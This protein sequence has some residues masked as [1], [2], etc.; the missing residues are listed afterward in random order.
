MLTFEDGGHSSLSKV[1]RSI[2]S[3]EPN[4]KLRNVLFLYA[5]KHENLD[6]C[7][8]KFSE[9]EKK[10]LESLE[11]SRK[12]IILPMRVMILCHHHPVL[13]NDH[14]HHRKS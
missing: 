4:Y 12:M 1:L 8:T 13:R 14:V 2:G 7:M 11:N 5:S 9:R 6:A 10:L 3:S